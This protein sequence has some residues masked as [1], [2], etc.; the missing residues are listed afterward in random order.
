LGELDIRIL[1]DQFLVKKTE[2]LVFLAYYPLLLIE[3]HID[4]ILG[5][6]PVV[7]RVIVYSSRLDFQTQRNLEEKRP[8]VSVVLAA[9]L[10]MVD[11]YLSWEEHLA[12]LALH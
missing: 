4:D 6:L 12:E 9:S 11:K 8:R 1:I 2:C 3:R 5:I 10:H 7:Y